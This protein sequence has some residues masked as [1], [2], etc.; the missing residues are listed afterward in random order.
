MS[1]G[2]SLGLQGFAVALQGMS[3]PKKS[4]APLL[5]LAG[6]PLAVVSG[7][8]ALVA[9]FDCV[10]LI[11]VYA[12]GGGAASSV[13]GTELMGGGGGG[14]AVFK[15]VRLRAGQ[16]LSY[17]VGAAGA[18]GNESAGGDGGNS[19]VTLPSGDVVVA[20]GGK[21]GVYQGLGTGGAGGGALRGDV[22][23][24]GGAGGTGAAPGASATPG[25]GNGAGPTGGG[26]GGGGGAGFGD[27]ATGMQGGDGDPGGFAGVGGGGRG[28]QSGNPAGAGGAGRIN[29][30]L[31]RES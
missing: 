27:L 30:V 4:S 9:D 5:G 3:V 6:A 29:I 1:G 28:R 25:G 11:Y 26:G 20:F 22:N 14:G 17:S 12:G 24:T 13:S 16:S 19:T 18:A 31:V 23:R 8:G 7:S 2:N 15:R 21:G 10:A